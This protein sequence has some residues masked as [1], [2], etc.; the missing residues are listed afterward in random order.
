MIEKEELER[1]KAK[2]LTPGL[3]E[4]KRK[5]KK[6]EPEPEP[7]FPETSPSDIKPLLTQLSN[8][9]EERSPKWALTETEIDGFS[10]SLSRL[11]NKYGASFLKYGVE[12]QVLFWV[13]VYIL[14]RVE[15]KK[16]AKAKEPEPE[17][18]SVRE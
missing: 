5:R 12:L 11:A 7:E 1:L 4:R 15:F 9:I 13:S 10:D 14:R 6:R 2:A 16:K 3:T 8:I 17:E 18:V